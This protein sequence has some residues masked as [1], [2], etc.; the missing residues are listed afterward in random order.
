MCRACLP[1]TPFGHAIHSNEALPSCQVLVA[2]T[3][4]QP[5]TLIFKELE[6]LWGIRGRLSNC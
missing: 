4:N 3:G 2:D 1:L 6:A 5:G